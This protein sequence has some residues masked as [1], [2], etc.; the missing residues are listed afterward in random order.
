[1]QLA[2]DMYGRAEAAFNS[3]DTFET[4]NLCEQALTHLRESADDKLHVQVIL[5]LLEA[6]RVR[7]QVKPDSSGEATAV[8]LADKAETLA[9][10][11]NDL[12]LIAQA[13]TMKGR[14]LISAG[15]VPKALATLQESLDIARASHDSFSQFVALSG[16]GH[17]LIKANLPAGLKLLYQAHELYQN[18]LQNVGRHT[19][20][21][22]A[23]LQSRIGIAEFDQGNYGDALTWLKNSIEGLRQFDMRD[24]LLV[25]LNFLAQLLIGI[26]L[27][28]E[29]EANLVEATQLLSE[30]ER[31]NPWNGNNL[32]LLGKLYL[33]WGRV[34]DAEAP[35][36]KGLEESESTLNADL[37]S[38]VRNYYAEML[39][40]PDCRHHD[41]N[42]AER[43]LK[44]NL[45]ECEKAVID[46][47]A[48]LS[49]S[50]LGQL[51]LRQNL[52]PDALRYSQQA[53]ERLERLGT[54]PAL[55]TE[56]VFFN[57]YRVLQAAGIVDKAS[58]YLIQANQVLQEKLNTIPGEGSR[59]Q[60]LDRVP[61]NRAIRSA[62]HRA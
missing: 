41:L 44:L 40:H 52:L 23:L 30:Q 22:F 36:Q 18:Q 12:T 2:N 47:S 35:L 59:N 27:F 34:E 28:E 57:H 9:V 3:G 33:E 49:L 58:Q 10:R 38:L 8:E 61:L 55:R 11:V 7:L 51:K 4:R 29:A 14:I 26:G 13:K 37:L 39:M 24:D 19:Q 20:Y 5:L 32:G 56:E 1:M 54:M 6:M 25:S 43:Q 50:M 31:P 48:I 53:V 42:A 62:A 17:Q 60:F 46:R 15:D 21:Q 45:E 16:L